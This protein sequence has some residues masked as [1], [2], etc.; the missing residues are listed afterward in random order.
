MKSEKGRIGP[1]VD[2]LVVLDF[3]D[4]VTQLRLPASFVRECAGE[5][6]GSVAL[7]HT[8]GSRYWNVNA[9]RHGPDALVLTI[10]WRHFVIENAL[11]RRTRELLGERVGPRR[12]SHHRRQLLARPR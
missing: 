11:L 4:R 10:G 3:S 5:M 9:E 2:L 12:S 7:Y 6:P 8:S 1:F